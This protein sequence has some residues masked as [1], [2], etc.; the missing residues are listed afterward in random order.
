MLAVEAGCS[1]L[2]KITRRDVIFADNRELETTL[3]DGRKL[4][5]F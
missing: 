2:I 4:V 1:G 3:C 5:I